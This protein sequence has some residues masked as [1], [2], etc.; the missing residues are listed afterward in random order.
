M[1][2][3]YPVRKAKILQLSFSTKRNPLMG[4]N[5]FGS[6]LTGLGLK[7]KKIHPQ[8]ADGFL[9]SSDD[10]LCQNF[11][12]D[13]NLSF[14]VQLTIQPESSV[15]KVH[16]SCSRAFCQTRCLQ[17]VMSSSFISSGF[18]NFSFRMCHF[19]RGL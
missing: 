3:F 5:R 1:D 14:V 18:R 12:L 11:F 15:W 7:T 9:I 19:M 4:S 13:D 16:F 2:V 8:L 6:K 17:L 10:L